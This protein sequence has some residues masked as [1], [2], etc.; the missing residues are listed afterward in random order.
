[1][2]SPLLVFII[3]P[4]LFPLQNTDHLQTARYI[5]VF[6]LNKKPLCLKDC[7]VE[8]AAPGFQEGEKNH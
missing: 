3:V 8:S 1:M 5:K 2:L 6:N 7:Q 4:H